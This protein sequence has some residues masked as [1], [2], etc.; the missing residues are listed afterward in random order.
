MFTDDYYNVKT[1]N[2][3]KLCSTKNVLVVGAIFAEESYSSLEFLYNNTGMREL[4]LLA[5]DGDLKSFVANSDF[6]ACKLMMGI[7]NGRCK[8]PCPIC[9]FNGAPSEAERI[10]GA[11]FKTYPQRSLDQW[12]HDIEEA[13]EGIE[14]IQINSVVKAPISQYFANQTSQRLAPPVLHINL[15]IVNT[16]LK[17]LKTISDQDQS[18]KDFLEEFQRKVQLNHDDYWNGKLRADAMKH[19]SWNEYLRN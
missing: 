16:C 15:G 19:R 11:A 12:S 10:E 4:E 13:S 3:G 14:S 2:N 6:K 18:I 7:E 8:H 17:D 5:L 9:T 1:K